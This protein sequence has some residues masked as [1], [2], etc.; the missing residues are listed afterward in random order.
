MITRLFQINDFRF[1]FIPS[2]EF[3]SLPGYRAT[4]FEPLRG[5][6]NFTIIFC[7]LCNG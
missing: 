5:I 4:T 7:H 3:A 1:L 6:G 2:G